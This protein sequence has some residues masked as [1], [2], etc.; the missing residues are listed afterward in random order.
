MKKKP[1][2]HQSDEFQNRTKKLQEL[3][4]LGIDPYP[5]IFQRDKLA[6]QVHEQYENDPVGSSEQAMEKSTPLIALSGRL[7]L[8]RAMGKNIFAQIQD[9][10]GRMQ[11][12][13]N[14]D[15]SAISGYT[16]NPEDPQAPKPQ[17]V[18]EKKADLGDFIG[19]RGY[20]FR[21]QKG[22]LTLLAQE[23]FFLC[24]S[25]L[26]LPDK[27][28]GLEDK[29]TRY[30]KRWLDL[31]A[32]KEVY[33]TFYTRSRILKFIRNYFD[34]QEFLEVETPVLQTIYGGAAARPFTTTLNAFNQKMFMRIALEISLKKLLVGGFDRIYEIGKV[35]RNE[36]IDRTHNPEFTM[37]EAYANSWDYEDMMVLVENLF[38]QLAL[39]LFNKTTVPF[40]A[41]DGQIVEIEMKA[42]WKRLSM[43]EAIATY[44]NI[45][46]DKLDDDHMRKILFDT[47]NYEKKSLEK[48]PR[49]LLIAK[50]FEEF[51]EAHLLAPHHIIDH[52]IETTPLCKPH[53]DPQLRQQGL[54]ER[55][56]SFIMGKEICN[57]YSE[58][59]DPEV[60]R[61]LL[62]A[63]AKEREDGD[64]EANPLDEEFIEAICQGMPPAG[65][66]GIGIDRLVML[67]TQASS[68][69]DVLFFPWMKPHSTEATE[70]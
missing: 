55:F 39:F 15:F 40:P 47:K 51:A 60:Q 5:P 53:R 37:L 26:P 52:P 34:K 70:S 24:K 44:G 30:R 49:G 6:A 62:E 18:F 35:F 8:S 21:T 14:R 4:A 66:L 56:E 27:H 2:Y 1:S 63:Q 19:V 59:N 29:E 38:E 46:V 45:E 64:E 50:L 42:P 17:K 3:K 9:A 69:R 13:V 20:L 22:E 32:N 36:G 61:D 16:P 11:I 57:A 12:M 67:F 25:L 31:I 58:L 65:G 54:V 48:L 33:D 43:I 10:T 68:I 7:V 28:S 41:A 23:V